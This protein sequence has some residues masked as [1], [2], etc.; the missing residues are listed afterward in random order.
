M[1]RNEDKIRYKE[2]LEILK[3]R[4]KTKYRQAKIWVQ[5][6]QQMAIVI[7]TMASG[8]IVEMIKISSKSR[9]VKEER[10]LKERFIYDR[11]SGHYYELRRQPKQS[12][13]LMI[14]QRKLNG[15]SLGMILQDMRLLK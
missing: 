13:W 6:N 8:A 5:E 11:G 12:E 15:E 7:A 14:E 3:E 10:A 9:T 4:V 1:I 2:N